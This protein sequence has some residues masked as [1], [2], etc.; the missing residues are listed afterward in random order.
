MSLVCEVLELLI[1][2]NRS[3]NWFKGEK[4]SIHIWEAGSC[5]NPHWLA[6]QV[7][8]SVCRSVGPPLWFHTEKSQ[9]TVGRISLTFYI[10]FHCPERMKSID[11]GDPLMMKCNDI[12]LVPLWAHTFNM[13]STL[14][15]DQIHANDWH[16]HQPQL[17]VWP[18]RS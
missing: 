6:F 16:S 3:K 9:Q 18:V 8:T 1:S 4:S 5:F 13:S 12:N 15:N 17:S 7:A 2:E 10:N 11:C 14:V